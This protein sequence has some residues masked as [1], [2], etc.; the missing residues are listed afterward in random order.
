M[1]NLL[2]RNL[3]DGPRDYPLNNGESIYLGS[4]GKSTGIV[5][6]SDTLIS[7]AI[8]AAEEKTLLSIEEVYE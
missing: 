8:R 7:K 4:K 5:K 2:I 6:I 3:C 1:S